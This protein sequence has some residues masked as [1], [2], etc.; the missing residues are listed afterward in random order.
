[1][2]QVLQLCA[3]GLLQARPV[4]FDLAEQSLAPC[5]MTLGRGMVN[6]VELSDLI[7]LQKT[8]EKGAKNN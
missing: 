4:L 2:R 1:M 6:L 7:T 3:A 5:F 8:G